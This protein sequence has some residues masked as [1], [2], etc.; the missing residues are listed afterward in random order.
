MSRSSC[1]VAAAPAGE[2]ALGAEAPR[3]RDEAVVPVVVARH[4][5]YRKRSLG[6]RYADATSSRTSRG[7]GSALPASASTNLEASGTRRP[8]RSRY[9]DMLAARSAASPAAARSASAAAPV[10][11]ATTKSVTL[12]LERCRAC[13]EHLEARRFLGTKRSG[14]RAGPASVRS[15]APTPR[16]AARSWRE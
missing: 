11:D 6:M 16:G 12:L 5:S 10:R 9:R 13:F 3:E 15:A 1:A 7:G 14:A 2:P 8:E 4:G